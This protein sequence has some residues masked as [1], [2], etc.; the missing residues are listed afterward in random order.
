[1]STVS[2]ENYVKAIFKLMYELESG[3][4][5]KIPEKSFRKSK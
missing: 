3:V 1:M 4:T 2:E 5:T